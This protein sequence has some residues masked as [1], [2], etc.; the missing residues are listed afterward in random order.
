MLFV[1]TGGGAGS[2][3]ETTAVAPNIIAT[4]GTSGPGAFFK[5]SL[6]T[7]IPWIAHSYGGGGQ[8]G[9]DEHGVGRLFRDGLGPMA[10]I[11]WDIGAR[12]SSAH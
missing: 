12:R 9:Q 1:E 10:G 4:I 8:H 11:W 6:G 3:R 2:M 7:P 5:A